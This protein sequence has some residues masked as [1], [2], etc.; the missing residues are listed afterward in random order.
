VLR[1]LV[2]LYFASI[3]MIDGLLD[4]LA[5]GLSRDDDRVKLLLIGV[6]DAAR[7]EVLA[8]LEVN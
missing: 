4:L 5:L 1:H 7:D 2:R 3:D 6:T 8:S